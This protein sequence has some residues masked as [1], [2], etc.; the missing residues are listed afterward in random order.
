MPNCALARARGRDERE[1]AKKICWWEWTVC[2][3]GLS[4]PQDDL[5]L[6]MEN[7]E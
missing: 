6:F 7:K 2:R 1:Y 3:R 4:K 5:M